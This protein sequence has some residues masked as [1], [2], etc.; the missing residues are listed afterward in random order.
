MNSKDLDKKVVHLVQRAPPTAATRN[1]RSLTPPPDIN[2][3]R[4]GL[5]G[6][7]RAGNPVPQLY[8][9]SMTLPQNLMEPQQVIPPR[10]TH[11][12]S[13]SRLNV[14]RR[15]ALCFSVFFLL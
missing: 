3:V 5:R 15:F 4:T 10:A 8:V 12:L 2:R 6:F 14:A 11:T 13:S 1:V 9:G 7:D